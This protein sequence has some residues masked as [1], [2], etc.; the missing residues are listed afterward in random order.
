MASFRFID[1]PAVM[2]TVIVPDELIPDKKS[3]MAQLIPA[4]F[5]SGRDRSVQ[6]SDPHAWPLASRQL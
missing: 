4:I 6:T 3:A 5:Y 1:A 2:Q